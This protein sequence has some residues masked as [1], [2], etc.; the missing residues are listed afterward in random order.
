MSNES[1]TGIYQSD[2]REHCDRRGCNREPETRIVT[3]A[4][5]VCDHDYRDGQLLRVWIVP[6][7]VRA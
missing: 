7:E 3:K 4:P 6:P 1:M 5:Q 2:D